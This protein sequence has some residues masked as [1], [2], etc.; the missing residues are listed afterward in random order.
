M[1]SV[2]FR[3]PLGAEVRGIS[4]GQKQKLEILKLLYLRRSLLFLDEPTSVLTPNEADEVLSLLHERPAGA[5]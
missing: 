1:E 4:A 5:I 2:P 3:L